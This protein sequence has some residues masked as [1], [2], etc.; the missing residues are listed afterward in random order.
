MA[1]WTSEMMFSY[2]LF[3][4]K[5]ISTF[6]EK[7]DC[8]DLALSSL[9]EFAYDNALPVKLKYYDKGWKPYDSATEA[10]KD[11]F[12]KLVMR[13]MGA[14]NVIDNTRSIKAA[15]AAPGDLIMTK[16]DASLGH[17]RIIYEMTQVLPGDPAT[18]Y[19]VVWYQGNLPAVV[20]ERREQLFS[21]IGNVFGG[22]PRRWNFEAFG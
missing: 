19:N 7:I 11:A 8:A 2:R 3:A 14:L 12:R 10:S 4:K 16:W 6:D 18:D 17:T 21:T 20:P 13:N 5:Y 15:D 1:R 22:T 9:V